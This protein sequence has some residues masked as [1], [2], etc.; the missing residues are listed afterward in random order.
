MSILEKPCRAAWRSLI[1]I[2]CFIRG[3]SLLKLGCLIVIFCCLHKHKRADDY[4]SVR[5]FRDEC[6][7]EKEVLYLWDV[8]YLPVF[9]TRRYH[10]PRIFSNWCCCFKRRMKKEL[11]IYDSAYYRISMHTEKMKGKKK[12]NQKNLSRTCYSNGVKRSMN[13]QYGEELLWRLGYKKA[14]KIFS[15][16]YIININED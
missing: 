10:P 4:L 12:Y 11:L 15:V 3:K 6:L 1:Q 16:P 9:V 7:E 5:V 8:L 13:T 14:M 2:L